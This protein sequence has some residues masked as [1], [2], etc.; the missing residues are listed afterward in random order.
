MNCIH[1]VTA[2]P[3]LLPPLH[4][5]STSLLPWPKYRV[6]PQVKT[7]SAGVICGGKQKSINVEC[8]PCKGYIHVWKPYA[9]FMGFNN[10]KLQRVAIRWRLVSLT[11]KATGPGSPRMDKC[12]GSRANC[13]T[14][15]SA[16]GLVYIQQLINSARQNGGIVVTWSWLVDIAYRCHPHHEPCLFCACAW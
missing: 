5:R 15:V 6:S 2:H 1:I 7:N 8:C 9:A 16:I 4:T 12:I 14:M 3:D 11:C 10:H 13:A